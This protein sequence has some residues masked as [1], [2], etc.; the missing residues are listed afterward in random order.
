MP[1]GTYTVRVKVNGNLIPLQQYINVDNAD[2]R[3]ADWTTPKLT[4]VQPI[5]APPGSMVTLS[6]DFKTLCYTRDEDSC[7]DD[8]GAR[9]SRIYFNGQICNLINPATNLFYQNLTTSTLLC[10]LEGHEVNMYNATVLVSEQYG[11]SLASPS[12]FYISADEQIYNF[13][14]YAEIF[15]VNN[16]TGSVNGGLKLSITGN[17]FYTDEKIRAEIKIGNEECKLIGFNQNNFY[18][19]NLECETPAYPGFNKSYF[20]GGRGVNLIIDSVETA[21]DNLLSQIPSISAVESIT[22]K[23]SVSFELSNPVTVWLKGY[24]AP[25]KSG[26]YDFTI[27]TNG[28]AIVYL[29]L[30]EDPSEKSIVSTNR[31]NFVQYLKV[32]LEA[33]K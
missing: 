3:V 5:S 18:D 21:F 25:L 27:N 24:F 20:Y 26:S 11:R 2:I 7:A 13:E 15:H 6:G 12:I 16:Q 29:S 23:M 19:S 4:S 31:P 33:G 10:R 17:H 1:E 30:S 28:Y 22:N 8:S 9:I 14:S 32:N